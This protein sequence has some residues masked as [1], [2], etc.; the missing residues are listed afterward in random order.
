VGLLP[1]WLTSSHHA[2][3]AAEANLRKN[4]SVAVELLLPQQYDWILARWAADK[5]KT[6]ID[7]TMKDKA[8]A[9]AATSEHKQSQFR[10]HPDVPATTSHMAAKPL[11][12]SLKLHL[13]LCYPPPR[14]PAP[15]PALH[16]HS[17]QPQTLIS[18][19]PAQ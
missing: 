16:P 9:A 11:L 1:G 15:L 18:A 17:L 14:R 10:V 3:H 12:C 4:T 13:L 19:R 8:A 5:T 7:T 2:Q 6:I